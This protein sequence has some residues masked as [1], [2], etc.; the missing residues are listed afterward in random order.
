LQ[1]IANELSV[2][3]NT[4]KSHLRHIYRKLAVGSRRDAVRQARRFGLLWD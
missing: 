1:D 4:V 2:S 3:P